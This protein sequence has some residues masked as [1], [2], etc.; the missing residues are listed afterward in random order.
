M[1]EQEIHVQTLIHNYDALWKG[2]IVLEPS[3]S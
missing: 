3:P 1:C 2:P